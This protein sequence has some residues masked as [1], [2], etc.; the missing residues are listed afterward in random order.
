MIIDRIKLDVIFIYYTQRE[1]AEELLITQWQLS[2][3]IKYNSFT[4]PEVD[5]VKWIFFKVMNELKK[6]L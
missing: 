1:L 4:E 2:E 5:K 3:R 6:H